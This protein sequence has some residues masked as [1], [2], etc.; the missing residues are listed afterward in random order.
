[1]KRGPRCLLPHPYNQGW[2]LRQQ[3]DSNRWGIC[4]SVRVTMCKCV[5]AL[6]SMIKT[7]KYLFFNLWWDSLVCVCGGLSERETDTHTQKERKTGLI[8]TIW[9]FL[10][11][12]KGPC[13][14]FS[15][16]S[17]YIALVRVRGNYT[18]HL[19]AHKFLAQDVVYKSTEISSEIFEYS[20]F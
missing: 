10:I 19:Y 13:H 12:I 18:H 17:R 6:G 3:K 8:N 20:N 14:R 5:Y 7:M 15:K 4:A 16:N 11:A 1:M 2:K 9:T